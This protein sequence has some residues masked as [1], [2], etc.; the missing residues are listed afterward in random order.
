MEII[1][2]V[3]G[4]ANPNRMNGV[5]KVVFQLATEQSKMGR[6]VSVWG[7]T[8]NI[9]HDYG[10]RNF[11]TLLFPAEQ[12]TFKISKALRLAIKAAKHRNTVFHIHGGWIP[13]FYSIS[14]I[15]KKH[16][17][18][19]V[20]TPHGSYNSIAMN[21]N[22]WVKKIY[23]ELFEKKLLNRTQK[24]HCIGKSE[25][26]GLSHIYHTPKTFLMP[27]GYK[28]DA[29][30]YRDYPREESKFIIGFIGRLDIHTK[31][32][33]LLIDAFNKFQENRKNTELW[34][35]GDSEQRSQLQETINKNALQGKVILW[36]K[37]F[38][39]EK[40]NLLQKMHVFAHPSRNEGLPSSVLEAASFGV[41]CIVSEATNVGSFVKKHECGIVVTNE[42]SEEI[43]EALLALDKRRQNKI[44]CKLGDKAREMVNAEFNWNRLVIEFDKLYSK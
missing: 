7:I 34:I 14:S 19:F 12:N 40:N 41:P 27:Y 17:I 35:I 1:H 11:K 21:K 15:L 20:F 23:F 33:D 9:T 8:K 18:P 32:L 16:K 6:D 5:N 3:L 26:E 2:L 39:E 31:G 25:I 24:I 42:N 4:K 28:N 44:L 37:K 22:K 38:G 36:G 10:N 43:T 13:T 30:S 29:K